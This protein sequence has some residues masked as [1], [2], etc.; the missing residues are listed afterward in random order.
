[1]SQNKLVNTQQTYC[2]QRRIEEAP[3]QARFNLSL[4]AVAH[5]AN[6]HTRNVQIWLASRTPQSA[7]YNGC[8]LS[9]ISS[10]IDA[11]FLNLALDAH[12]PP[13]C[14]DAQIDT[15][16]EKVKSFFAGREVPFIWLLSPFAAPTDMEERLRRHNLKQIAYR[17]PA[18]VAPLNQSQKW[19]AAAGEIEVWQAQS[20]ADLAAASDIRRRAFQFKEHAAQH[21]F[22]DMAADWLRGDPARLY[23][24]RI[25]PEGPPVAIGALI[26]GN[27][28]PGVYVMATLPSWE[29]RGLGKA[30][31]K[32]I[33]STAKA[34]GHTR[35]VLTAGAKA[36]SLYRKFGFEHIF[37]YA[38]YT[39]A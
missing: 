19:P 9:A 38:M 13:Q 30:V 6:Q 26:M 10:G 20:R 28:V 8:G 14:S 7:R 29:G 37:E 32:R 3:A 24:A 15:E 4:D 18:M 25:G 27:A 2:A 23:L 33:L 16:I 35:I 31:L 12:Y 5:I 21:Y 11:A 39:H 22:E 1:M 17:L 34:E 36:Y